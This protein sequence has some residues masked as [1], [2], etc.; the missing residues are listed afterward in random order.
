VPTLG[1]SLISPISRL[2]RSG[3]HRSEGIF[4]AA[5]PGLRQ[6]QLS[7]P[8]SLCDI[9]PTLYYMS[10]LPIPDDMDAHLISEIWQPQILDQNPPQYRSPLPPPQTDINLRPHEASAVQERL[11][12]LGYL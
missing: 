12:G 7:Q 8:P 6:G 2:L 5:G 11:R 3:D 9:A 10:G 1:S 4:Q